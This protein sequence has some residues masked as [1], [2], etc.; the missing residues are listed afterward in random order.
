VDQ[1]KKRTLA[2]IEA[3]VSRLD[4]RERGRQLLLVAR[5]YADD[6]DLVEVRRILRV[7]EARFYDVLPQV[8]AGDAEVRL[9]VASFIDALGMDWIL[10]AMQPRDVA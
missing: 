10:W 8:A 1:V 2:L 9:A 3:S 5:D 4:Y 7:V 6:G